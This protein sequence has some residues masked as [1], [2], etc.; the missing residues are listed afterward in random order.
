MISR[1]IRR[2]TT[3]RSIRRR[4][5]WV[6][7]DLAWRLALTKSVPQSDIDWAYQT[8]NQGSAD[9]QPQTLRSGKMLSGSTGLNGLA[10]SKPETFQVGRGGVALPSLT[11]METVVA[12]RPRDGRQ[13]RR[14]L[15]L[16][17]D[18]RE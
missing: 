3:R 2:C 9:G 4:L 10:W 8:V 6:P 14:Q 15:E 11:D 18:L 16:A 13:R 12:R 17:A 7:N 1:T 5:A